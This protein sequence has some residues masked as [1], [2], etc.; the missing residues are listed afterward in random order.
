MHQNLIALRT[1]V[2]RALLGFAL[3]AIPLLLYA[4]ELYHLFASPLLAILPY[5]QTLIATQLISTFLVPM[6]LSLWAAFWI[7]LPWSLWQLWA[8]VKPALYSYE[9]KR[10]AGIVTLSLLL[11]YG[12]ALFA[13]YVVCPLAMRF[14]IEIAPIGVQVMTDINAYYDFVI[15]MLWA[16][17]LG[18]QVPVA[19]WVLCALNI[20]TA[21]QLAHM[22]RYVIVGAFVLAMILTPP[23]VVSQVL[24]AVPLCFLFEAGLW[25]ARRFCNRPSTSIKL[26]I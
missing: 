26:T 10:F 14:F 25:L 22:R 3:F 6:K 17:G 4:P 9:K 2:I 20:T 23:D 8:F 12:G 21:N 5:Q 15:N 19:L 13:Y 16:F 24:L 7:T 18:F 11:F 1:H